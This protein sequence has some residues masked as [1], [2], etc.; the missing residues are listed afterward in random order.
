M[1]TTR[2]YKDGGQSAPQWKPAAVK[3]AHGPEAAYHKD[4]AE[5]YNLHGSPEKGK[6]MLL[7][8]QLGYLGR[9]R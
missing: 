3:H 1:S 6:C 8:D 4:D 7:T 9:G 5:A 2:E